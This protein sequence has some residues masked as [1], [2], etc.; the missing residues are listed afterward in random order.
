ML[1]DTALMTM[2]EMR[3]CARILL[4]ARGR[5]ASATPYQAMMGKRSGRRAAV[6]GPCARL[7]N[8][9]GSSRKVEVGDCSTCPAGSTGCDLDRRDPRHMRPPG[10]KP[11]V[12]T[13]ASGRSC[14]LRRRFI[15]PIN[16]R[17]SCARGRAFCSGQDATKSPFPAAAHGPR[18][19]R[20]IGP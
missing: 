20:P 1:L 13:M 10:A 2:C 14:G 11:S 6:P 5:I 16:H 8:S 4:R 19:S 3:S 17:G 15:C 18:K 7:Q 12:P 9:L